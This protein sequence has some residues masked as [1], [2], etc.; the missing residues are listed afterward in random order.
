MSIEDGLYYILTQ[1]AALSALVGDKVYPM[2]GV[3]A[4]TS[5]PYVAYQLVTGGREVHQTDQSAMREVRYQFDCVSTSRAKSDALGEAVK[6]ALAYYGGTVP[7]GEQIRT[8]VMELES[9]APDAPTD[10]SQSGAQRVVLD[11]VIWFVPL[12]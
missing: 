7:T 9:V 11:F 1:D 3:P 10:G 8:A 2:L 4:D 12:S 5:A 6:G